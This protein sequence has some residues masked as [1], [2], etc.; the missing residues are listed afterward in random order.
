MHELWLGVAAIAQPATALAL[1]AGS[2][3]GIVIGVLPGVGPGVA[4]AAMPTMIAGIYGM[5]FTHM[6]ELSWRFGY[7]YA[8]ALMVTVCVLLY[9]A[10][11]RSGWL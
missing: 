10:F 4:I 1:L 7:G 2:L 9:R 11:R 5:N 6:P 8:L 3:L